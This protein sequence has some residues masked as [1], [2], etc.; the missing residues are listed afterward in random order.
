M[1]EG[2]QQGGE[3]GAFQGELFDLPLGERLKI[4]RVEQKQELE[5]AAY[6]LK[7]EASVLLAIEEGDGPP[8]GLPE[9]F[10]QGVIRN[11][12][13]LLE[14]EIRPGDLPQGGHGRV[15]AGR[16]RHKSDPRTAREG[17]ATQLQGSVAPAVDR[18]KELLA[19]VDGNWVHW[20]KENPLIPAVVL[21]LVIITFSMFSGDEEVATVE[22]EAGVVEQSAEEEEV[23]S[24]AEAAVES[25][26]QTEQK[27]SEAESK[28]GEGSVVAEAPVDAMSVPRGKVTLRYV[29]G[30]W[31]QIRDGMGRVLVKRMLDAGTIEDF[32]GPLPLE[33]K[34]GNAIGVR[35][36]FNEA[37]FDHLN[38]IEDNNTAEFVLG[39][40]E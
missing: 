39:T 29:D 17:V 36:H 28:D 9:V 18:A 15:E 3:S 6:Q 12:A 30:S 23:S 4:A 1:G 24:E 21:L 22:Q 26:Q 34:L 19:R 10:Y 14:V 37:P 35:V 25:Q 2:S 32:E 16:E 8:H 40:V 11:Y 20:I 7:L 27:Q 5:S 13:R 31:T 33:V 38:Y